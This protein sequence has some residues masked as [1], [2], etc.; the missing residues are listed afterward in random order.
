MDSKNNI[1]RQGHWENVYSTKGEQEVSWFQDNPEPSLDLIA[2]AGGNRDSGI[3]DIGGGAARLVDTL[4]ADGYKDITVL[5]LSASALEVA[6]KRLGPGAARAAW[7]AADATR[8]IPARTYDIWHDRA[9]FHFLTEPDDQA[10]YVER[11]RKALRQ[12]GHAVIGTFAPDGPEKCS[13]LVVARH[14]PESLGR[15]LG[16]AFHLVHARRH[17]HSTPWQATQLFQFSVFRFG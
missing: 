7:I 11:L 6:K 14:D 17:E 1:D 8:W 13:G 3:I 5:D 16:Q 15:V 2:I 12:G 10:A 4:L 9:A